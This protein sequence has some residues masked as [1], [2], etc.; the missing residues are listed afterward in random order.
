M[1]SLHQHGGLKV[2]EVVKLSPNY[3]QASINRHCKRHIGPSDH[4][5]K[6]RFDRGWPSKITKQ[7]RRSIIRSM[8]KLRETEGSFITKNCSWIRVLRGTWILEISK[9]CYIRKSIIIGVCAKSHFWKEHICM[10]EKPSVKQSK[11]ANWD[12]ISG[13]IMWQC[14]WIPKDSNL[15]LD[16]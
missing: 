15:K 3:S 10:L 1:T 7:D 6:T 9:W 5:D 2:K 13:R 12:R 14:I 8:K 11:S 4:V 16:L